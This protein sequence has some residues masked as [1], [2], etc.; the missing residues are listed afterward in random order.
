MAESL[1]G[2][3][4][5]EVLV[6]LGDAGYLTFLDWRDRGFGNYRARAI[7]PRGVQVVEL[8][9]GKLRHVVVKHLLFERFEAGL[10][11]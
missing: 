8:L 3:I 7:F 9:D 1:H 5:V 6:L 4:V 10:R 11:R 2:E